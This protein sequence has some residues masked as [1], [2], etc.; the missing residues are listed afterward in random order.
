M[1]VRKYEFKVGQTVAKNNEYL[2]KMNEL[3]QLEKEF[4]ELRTHL[5][6]AI[7]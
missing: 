1:A 5:L 6:T 2:R 7:E 3:A 4:N